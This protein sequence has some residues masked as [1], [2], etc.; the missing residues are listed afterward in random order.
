MGNRHY[1]FAFLFFIIPLGLIAQKTAIY[2]DPEAAYRSG[3]DLFEK[4]KYGAA[5]KDFAFVIEN[6]HNPIALLRVNA[7][8]YDALCALELYNGDAEYKFTEFLR[9]HPSSSRVNL[10][11]Y[12]LGRLAYTNK[13]YNSAQD[14]FEKVDES[15]L[16]KEQLDEFYFKKAYSYFKT[17]AAVKAKPYFEKVRNRNSKYASP[18]SY[19]LAHIAYTEGDYEAAL[20][21]FNELMDDDNFKTVAPYYIIQILFVQEKYDEVLAMAP[22]MLE[23]ANDKRA[24][25][26]N[27][28]IG[29]SYYRTGHY[30]EALPY[31]EQYHSAKGLAV[32]REDNYSY[33]FCLYK[34]KQY[35]T[36]G[37]YFQ[38]VTGAQDELSQYAYYY[39]ADCY[40][41]TGQKQ[42]AANAFNSAYKLTFDTDIRED[43]LFNQAQLAFD[44]SFDPYSEAI[45]ALK[46]YLRNYP[47]SSRND[48]AYNFLFRIS[49]ATGN[50]KDA[51]DALDHIKQKGSDYNRNYQKISLYRGI[52]YFNQNNDEEAIKMFKKAVE[53]DA[54]K[55]VAA[56]AMFWAGE[57]FYRSENLWGAKKYYSD[58]LKL[59]AAKQLPVYN[60]ANYNL[61][62]VNFRNK[63]YGEAITSFQAFISN[64]KKEE[65]SMTADASLRLGDSY[66]I[67]KKYDDAISNYDKAL[68]MGILDMDYALFQK[69][70][71]LG[72]LSRYDEKIQ[73][74]NKI[75]KTYPNSSIV[76]EAQYELGNTYLI[77]KDNENALY[78]FKKVISDYPKSSFAVK[79]RLKSGLIYYNSEQ[80]DL[81]LSTF[82]KVVEEFPNS[83]ESKEALVSIKNIYVE[84]NKVDD[85]FAYTGDLPNTMVRASEQDSLTYIS[86]E[87]VYLNSDYK[88]AL[89]VFERYVE[90]FPKGAFIIPASFYLGDCQ[91]REGRKEEAL[92]N[93]ETV[94]EAPRSEF[95]ESALAKAAALSYG[96]TKYGQALAH[97]TA[98]EG[99][100][101]N[102]NNQMEARYGKMKCNFMLKDYENALADAGKLLTDE[103]L[104]NQMKT[105]AM[106]IRAH[107]YNYSDELPLAKSEYKKVADL[108][109]GEAGA[110]AM[111]NIAEI[112][113][114]LRDTQA[115]EKTVFEL[116]NRYTA[117]DY[118]VARGFILL[119]DIYVKNGNNFQAKQTLQSI[120][121][122]Y[123]GDDLRV[124]ASDKLAVIVGRENLIIEESRNADTLNGG[125][126]IKLKEEEVELQMK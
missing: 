81:A 86:A 36:A 32:A 99:I 26:I 33:G 93:L 70:K 68:K 8:Y 56:E 102:R 58:F 104:S 63:D 69:A 82:K 111:F 94:I 72:V 115:S 7:E 92:K 11:Q 46:D 106:M 64:A 77:Q 23:T 119:S 78:N 20:T 48:D 84:M 66:F 35:K 2:K 85:Y 101:E 4:E 74:L 95:T 73:T 53:L 34:A 54:D 38:K 96:L 15:E 39:L 121:D 97:Y 50:Y 71:A 61:G 89:P 43:A 79:A 65:P 55:T 107:A 60:I 9:R 103:K 3:M 118:W 122:N 5:Q 75:L 62:Y 14:Y 29:E 12:Q 98:L 83:P 126:T 18:A 19:Y 40:L 45:K 125:E 37:D 10:I 13:K 52:E 67:S 41:Q 110:E 25:E 113:F 117:Y 28:V 51:Q 114:K 105:E 44:L 21:G 80:Y 87:K 47:N 112:E 91:M 90:K 16:S 6:E 17:D 76:S 88:S 109:Q 123:E 49:M 100:A 124:I 120:I 42:Y 116:I 108:S 24:P 27:R 1:K 31:L 59:A 22:G 57:S 30:E